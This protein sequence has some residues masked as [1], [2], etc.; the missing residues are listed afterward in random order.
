MGC[1]RISSEIL[2]HQND[3]KFSQTP[4]TKVLGGVGTFFQEG[5]DL[6][7]YLSTT[8]ITNINPYSVNAA[9]SYDIPVTT[10]YETQDVNA[11]T[12]NNNTED[13]NKIVNSFVY[14]SK[15]IGTLSISGDII[16]DSKYNN[17][18]AYGILQSNSSAIINYKYN[19]ALPAP[20]QGKKGEWEL[21]YFDNENSLVDVS[22]SKDRYCGV[23]IIQTS[24]DDINWT[25]KE[26]V[27]DVLKNY[28]S[29]I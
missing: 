19:G 5:S 3:A 2:R 9:T 27:Y 24:Y 26:I 16:S 6:P 10:C 15:S 23:M 1:R 29:I 25:T 4:D 28:T 13:P 22:I 12:P 20:A 11:N 18:L 17:Y 14:G 7:R 8:I 21:G